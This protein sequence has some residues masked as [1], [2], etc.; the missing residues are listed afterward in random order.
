MSKLG[1]Y[2]SYDYSV[3]LSA[4]NKQI[5]KLKGEILKLST[6]A[7]NTRVQDTADDA[8]IEENEDLKTQVFKR[9]DIRYSN[10]N[11]FHGQWPLFFCN[12]R[13]HNEIFL[14]STIN[15]LKI[16]IKIL[17]GS[18]ISWRRSRQR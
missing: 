18:W 8:L 15:S 4:A 7:K 14:N 1:A 3:Q 2:L 13:G 5:A 11:I 17:S 6:D 10:Y 16:A 12:F 9:I